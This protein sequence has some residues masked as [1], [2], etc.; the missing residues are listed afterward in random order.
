VWRL[1]AQRGATRQRVSRLSA[2]SGVRSRVF[3]ARGPARPLDGCVP[4]LRHASSCTLLSAL[5]G[6]AEAI[7]GRA[8]RTLRAAVHS[9]TGE[10]LEQRQPLSQPVHRA[11]LSRRRGCAAPNRRVAGVRMRNRSPASPFGGDEDFAFRSRTASRWVFS[12][13]IAGAYRALVDQPLICSGRP[14]DG[15]AAPGESHRRQP[16]LGC[17]SR[18]F[19]RPNGGPRLARAGAPRGSSQRPLSHIMLKDA[20]TGAVR[21]LTGGLGSD[22]PPSWRNN[23]GRA[24]A[25]LASV[26]ELGPDAPVTGSTRRAARR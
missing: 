20:R 25:L 19:P 21:S 2:R 8:G 17:P 5:S 24:R 15:S 12:A 11:A 10:C 1:N 23:P 4:G 18:C 22:R 13:R 6:R 16:R 3:S 7:R 9:G 14:V 26:D